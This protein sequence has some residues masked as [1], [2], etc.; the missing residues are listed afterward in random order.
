MSRSEDVMRFAEIHA[1]AREKSGKSQEYV[2]MELGVNKKT[3]SNWENGISAPTFFQS[4][5]YFKALGI[6]PFPLY[7]SLVYPSAYNLSP[8]DEEVKITEAFDNLVE[9]L[10]LSTKKFLL[11]LFFGQH[12]GNPSSI[13]ELFTAYLHIPLTERVLMATMIEHTYEMNRELGTI[14]CPDNVQPD[15][16]KLREASLKAR[17]SAIN[18]EYGYNAT[19]DKWA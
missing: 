12:G 17:I 11:F 2:A 19:P 10:P 6:N 18:H 7:L 8:S 9:T 16:E 5:E 14:I 13:I 3:I 4:L 15:I 1:K